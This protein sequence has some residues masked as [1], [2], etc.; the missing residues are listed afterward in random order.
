MRRLPSRLV[1]IPA[2]SQYLLT[3]RH[4]V[5]RPRCCRA[6][7]RPSGCS[8][9]QSGPFPVILDA[10]LRHVAQDRRSRVEQYRSSLLG[11]LLGHFRVILEAV[12]LQMADAR[13]VCR[14]DAAPGREQHAHLHEV[15]GALDRHVGDWACMAAC[16]SGVSESMELSWNRETFA[17]SARCEELPGWSVPHLPIRI[18]DQ[19]GK[20]CERGCSYLGLTPSGV[21]EL[22]FPRVGK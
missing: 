20:C 7:L 14:R 4:G 15:T 5:L 18:A 9:L 2:A 17:F 1:S 13:T 11:T 12:G 3:S 6:R 8:D 22:T 21:A 10:G 16:G 19:P